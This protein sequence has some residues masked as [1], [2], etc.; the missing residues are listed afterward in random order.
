MSALED[1]QLFSQ[2]DTNSKDE[3]FSLADTLILELKKTEVLLQEDRAKALE[4]KFLLCELT[5]RIR[6]IFTEEYSGI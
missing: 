2:S 5:A 1:R 4:T 6:N 3:V